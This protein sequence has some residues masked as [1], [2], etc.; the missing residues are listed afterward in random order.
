MNGKIESAVEGVK[1][2]LREIYKGPK[3]ELKGGK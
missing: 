1:K 2:G 3:E